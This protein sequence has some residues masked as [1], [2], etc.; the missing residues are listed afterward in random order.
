MVKNPF[1]NSGVHNPHREPY[2]NQNLVASDTSDANAILRNFFYQNSSTTVCW[3]TDKQTHKGK[4]I[5]FSTDVINALLWL[6]YT[7]Q[8][9]SLILA[10][11]ICAWDARTVDDYRGRLSST[12]RQIYLLHNRSRTGVQSIC[13]HYSS[14]V[15]IARRLPLRFITLVTNSFAR[16]AAVATIV[17]RRTLPI[18]AVESTNTHST[19]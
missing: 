16:G 1:K 18:D 5:A 19:Q 11:L 6:R 3:K 4:N 12:D 13:I 8:R 17:Q 15:I 14:Q 2:H 7:E 9:K 10:Q